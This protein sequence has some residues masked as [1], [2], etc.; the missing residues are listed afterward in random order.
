M[1][2]KV[3]CYLEQAG[4]IS[5]TADIWSK[6]GLTSSYLGITGHFFSSKDHRLPSSHTADNIHTIVE[7]ILSEWEIPA[8]KI[9]AILTDNGSNIVA[10]F[11]ERF[12]EE[13]ECEDESDDSSSEPEESDVSVEVSDFERHEI[14]HE[15]AFSCFSHTLQLVVRQFDGIERFKD[16]LKR[17]HSLIKKVNSSTKTT[18]KLVSVCGKKLIRDCPT[19]WSSTFLLIERLLTV[20]TSLTSVLEELEWDSLATSEWKVLEGVKNLLQPFAVLTSLISGE[21]F[22]TISSVY[23]AI[24]EIRMHLEEVNT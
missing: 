20:K 19:R 23:P 16:L 8:T 10:A 12:V 21:D 2:A 18:E 7:E 1:R 11:C 17:T 14:E 5:I 15:V 3:G 24:V 22:T 13:E 9:S 4:R 6:K